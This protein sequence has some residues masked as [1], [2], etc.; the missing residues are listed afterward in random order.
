MNLMGHL[1]SPD[2]IGTDLALLRT[3]SYR[4]SDNP[5]HYILAEALE[6]QYLCGRRPD[7]RTAHHVRSSLEHVR[8]VGTLP[9]PNAAI[10]AGLGIDLEVEFQRRAPFRYQ[11]RVAGPSP[12]SVVAVVG[13]PRSGT[14]HLV[15]LLAATRRFAYFTTASCWAW[16][17]WNLNH[18]KR[19]MFNDLDDAAV[20][21]VLAVDNKRTRILPGL[22]MP[23]EAEDVYARAVPVYRHLGGHRYLMNVLTEGD[24][25]VLAAGCA[26][27][28]EYFGRRSFLTKSPFNSLRI[29][30]LE[31]VWPGKVRY[32]HIVRDRAQVAESMRRNGFDFSFAIDPTAARDAWSHF[33]DAISASAPLERLM[34]ISYDDIVHRTEPTMNTITAW[35]DSA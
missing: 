25:D 14:S 6:E 31:K 24:L 26:A 2:P 32:L 15:N 1:R 29:P 27:H 11:P 30:I 33:V 9:P 8:R 23:G 35:L 5:V 28:L 19:V 21:D 13:A 22:V 12:D 3:R 10:I 16:P 18:P 17:T 7:E 34:T 20:N 4:F